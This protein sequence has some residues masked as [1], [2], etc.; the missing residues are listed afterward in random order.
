MFLS[1][2]SVIQVVFL[3]GYLAVRLARIKTH[4]LV[5]FGVVVVAVSMLLNYLCVLLAVTLGIYTRTFLL[6]VMAAEGVTLAVSVVR[7][8]QRGGDDAF[9]LP[10]PRIRLDRWASAYMLSLAFTVFVAAAVVAVSAILKANVFW[11]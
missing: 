9:E 11:A 1:V 2:L 6:I 8:W 4:S 5:E 3:P 7:Q 10:L